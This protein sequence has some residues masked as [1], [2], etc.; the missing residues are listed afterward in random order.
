MASRFG[1]LL[2]QWRQRAGLSQEALAERAELGVRT[3]RGLETGERGDPRV[4][5]L[6]LLADALEL[7]GAERAELFAATGRAEPPAEERSADEAGPPPPDAD[8]LLDALKALAHLM[9]ARWQREEEHRQV[10][11]PVPLPVRWRAAPAALQD[12][13]A[14]IGRVEVGGAGAGGTAP[15][16]DL[17]GRLDQVVPVYRRIPSGR[18]VVLGRAG[19]G[20]TILTTRFVLDL[21]AARGPADPVPVIFGLGAWNPQRAGLRDWL[22]EQ[23]V[24]DAPDLAAPG[25]GGATLAAALVDDHRVLPV[26]DGFDEVAGGLRRAALAAL[27]ATTLPVLLTS[28]AE[29]YRAAVD[30]TDVLTAAAAVELVDLTADDLAGYLPR[31]TRRT[32]PAGNAWQ[33][34][35]DEVRRDPDGALAA[36]LTTPL[37]VSLA[38]R[39]YSD[40]PDH[41]PAE[42]LDADRFGT[43]EAVERHLLAEFVPAVYREPDGGPV[44]LDRARRGLG[45]LA[46][47][48]SRLGTHDLAWW[49]L[50]TSARRGARALVVG[51]AVFLAVALTDVLV[52]GPFLEVPPVLLPLLAAMIGVNAGVGFAVAHWH[53]VGVQPLEPVRFRL[54]LRGGPGPGWPRVRS[55]VRLGL[56]GGALVGCSYGVLHKLAQWSLLGLPVTPATTLFDAV[57]FTAV[58]GAAA[59]L[60]L[61]LVT[62]MEA[63]LDVRSA[64]SPTGLLRANR[65][66]VLVQVV[67]FVPLFAVLIAGVTWLVALAV[68]GLPGGRLFGVA[69][70]WTPLTGLLLGLVG[71]LGGGIGYVLGLT[72]WGQWVVFARLWLPLT[73]RLPWA[74]PAFLD[75]AYRRG[76]LRRAG[77]VYQFRHARLQEHLAR[78]HRLPT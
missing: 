73:G 30:A 67:L 46:D 28:R 12:D 64:G 57:L 78:T 49:Q 68:A 47:H 40:T 32:G 41:D 1:V 14:N 31:T 36:V 61:G 9:R 75:D 19:A 51:C 20:K 8:P 27:N 60:V 42:L 11:D 54:R 39:I 6:R 53:V 55:R 74:V 70:I 43:P 4:G 7:T 45:Y 3:I 37:M 22:A 52:E 58:F 56:L 76:V 16:V 48:L 24:R 15:G 71:G 17:T 66:A 2:R 23:L 26:L 25:P 50:G 33:P 44:D 29:E 72:A 69:V 63:P 34:V 10:H 21:L 13:W 18:L 77:A 5:T 65:T 35:L 59:A 38:R 62:V